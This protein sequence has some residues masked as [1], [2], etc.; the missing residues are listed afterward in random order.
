MPQLVT[1]RVTDGITKTV[2]FSLLSNLPNLQELTTGSRFED[3][4]RDDG[5]DIPRP[6]IKF[7]PSRL[8]RLHFTSSSSLH[9]N[10]DH[11]ML[12]EILPWVPDLI[13]IG[14]SRLDCK[15]AIAIIFNC[16]QLQSLRHN[17]HKGAICQRYG[18][19]RVDNSP[20]IVLC[21]S[22]HLTEFDGVR[23]K[24]EASSLVL[25]PWICEGLVELRLQ[26]V[27]VTRLTEEEEMDY[28]QGLL[29]RRL[30]RTLLEAETKAL[31]KYEE[32]RK[33]H[34]KIYGQLAKLVHLKTLELGMEYRVITLFRT[35]AV[36]NID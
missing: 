15:I 11:R 24:I 12:S 16:P 2:F 25:N 34:C 29:L 3:Y 13:E 26:I 33:Q 27:G 19:A 17:T 8:Q 20:G 9:Q 5:V 10:E 30:N 6:E 28:K 14:V 22:I 18:G 35:G 36:V 23:L 1:L 4:T 21:N 7:A 32:V 31:E